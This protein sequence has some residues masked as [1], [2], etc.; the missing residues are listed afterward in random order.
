MKGRTEL[1]DVFARLESFGDRFRLERG[2][3]PG[4]DWIGCDRL[5]DP[6]SDE[7]G[8]VLDAERHASGQ[9]S[10]HA[11]AL[12]VMA[13]YAGTVTAS[14]LLAWAIDGKVIDMRPRNVAIR[15]SP[16]HGFEAVGLREPTVTEAPV[17]TL[18]SWVL[19]DHL[20]PL[21]R[22][23]RIRTRAGLRQLN[24]GVAHG[25][26]AAFCI[27][28]R[29]GGDVD[30]LENAY[31]AFLTAATGDLD[32]LGTVIR[33]RED[34]RE[35]LFYLRNTCC[36]YYTSAEQVKCSSCCLDTVEDRVTNYRRV[37]AEGVVPH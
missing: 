10:D 8:R 24:G 19:D 28:S 37:L 14:A 36:L 34:D 22:A 20:L 2:L 4:Q 11:T 13:V 7:L 6:S 5:L 17:E 18:V 30:Q 23:M 12:T 35:G 27:A 16:H 33:L 32:R 21:A 25:C 15:L 31:H 29:R 26:A 9:V 3:A 1:T